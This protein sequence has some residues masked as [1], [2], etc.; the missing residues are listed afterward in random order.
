MKIRDIISVVDVDRIEVEDFIYALRQMSRGPDIDTDRM[1]DALLFAMYGD[2]E[3]DLEIEQ[4]RE[5]LRKTRAQAD[6][7]AAEAAKARSEVGDWRVGR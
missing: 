7:L 4:Q 2:E 3:G 5:D 1:D 6:K